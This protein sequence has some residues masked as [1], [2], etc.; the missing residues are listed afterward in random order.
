MRGISVDIFRGRLCDCTNSG[1]THPER[2]EGKTFVVFDESI[3]RGNFVLEKCL[4][5]PERYICLKV[6]RRWVGQPNEYM[7]VEPINQPEGKIGPMAGGNFVYS[8]DSRF[9]GRY[10]LSVHDR[11]ETQEQYD[12]L[13]R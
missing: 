5:E 11:F 2:A 3:E 12:M 10:P 9:P 4:A 13:S 6:V 1:V 7:H 8:S